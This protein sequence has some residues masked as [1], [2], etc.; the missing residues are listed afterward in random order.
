MGISVVLPAYL[1]ADN[2]Q[3]L[4]P[5]IHKALRA[6]GEVYEII[7]VDTPYPL[8]NTAEVC[9]QFKTRCIRRKRPVFGSAIRAGIA[10]ARMDKF[11][12][13]DADGSHDPRYI[14][15]I[16]R[17]FIQGADVVIGSR[18]TGGGIT[19]DA[20]SSVLASR[21]LNMVARA[22]L[23]LSARDISTNFRMYRT[24]QLKAVRLRCDHFDIVQEIL[25][26]LRQKNPNLVIA[27]TPIRFHKR[28]YGETKRD[29]PHFLA[30]YAVTLTRLA[31]LR[32]RGR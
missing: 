21:L 22:A 12:I 7:V 13:M 11:L 15:A 19:H 27:E 23:G 30:G 18:Y 16:H 28:L 3:I 31:L 32:L 4:L 17:C 25:M 26:A 14:P 29:M 2:L 24:E 9:R 1:E 20:V 6:T 5:R 10:A 8:D